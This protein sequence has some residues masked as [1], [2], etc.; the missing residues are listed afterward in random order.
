MLSL[1]FHF[2][3]VVIYLQFQVGLIIICLVVGVVACLEDKCGD[4]KGSDKMCGPFIEVAVMAVKEEDLGVELA[5]S[6][7]PT[8]G[9]HC[10]N[11]AIP[12]H[13][14]CRRVVDYPVTR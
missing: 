5:S 9:T 8:E 4:V 2:H 11:P 14:T 12:I 13:I 3:Y 1:L 7:G 6:T 10:L